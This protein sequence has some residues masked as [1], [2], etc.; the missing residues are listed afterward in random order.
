MH[1]CYTFCSVALA[2]IAVHGLGE[3]QVR[4]SLVGDVG[5]DVLAA[6]GAVDV[7][8]VLLVYELLFPAGHDQHCTNAA[9]T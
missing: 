8:N 9:Q 6:L 5:E 7:H 2:S 1:G 4:D 3:A